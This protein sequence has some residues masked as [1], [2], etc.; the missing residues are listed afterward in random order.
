MIQEFINKNFYYLFLFT[1]IFGVMFYDAIRFNYTDEICVLLLLVLYVYH[2]VQ[3]KNWEFSK[4]FLVVLAVFVFYLGYSFWI[5]SNAKKAIVMDFIIQI[6]PYLGF[7]CAYSIAPRFNKSQ[8]LILQQIVIIFTLYLLG[9]GIMSLVNGDIMDLLLGHESRFATAVSILALLYLYSVDYSVKDKFFFILILAIGL[10]STRSKFYGF[11]AI[12]IFMVIYINDKFRLQFNLK[13][14][15]FL[16]VAV[17]GTLFVAREKIYYYFVEGGFGS[18]REVDDLYARMALY[19][20]SIPL[21]VDYFPFGSGFATYA[22]FTSGEYY[23]PIYGKYGMDRMHG[24]TE[25]DPAF[26]ADTYYPALAQFGVVGVVLFFLFWIHLLK[27]TVGVFKWGYNKEAVL[28]LL[29]IVF[30]LIECTSDATITH[31]RGVFMM[32]FLGL[33]YAEAKG[34]IVSGEKQKPIPAVEL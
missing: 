34:Q 6:K 31:N 19:Y 14:T 21:F 20:Y 29:V 24:L 30:F 12:S 22:T 8:K 2:V 27:K 11:L 1:L 33:V 4:L 17:A 23:S 16:L 13:N 32:M 10:F 7:F 26:I 5:G 3:T 25:A 15:L 9:I 28:M 18:G